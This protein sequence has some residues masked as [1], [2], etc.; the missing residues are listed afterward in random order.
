MNDIQDADEVDL[1]ISPFLTFSL[2]R[3]EDKVSASAS[4]KLKG[5]SYFLNTSVFRTKDGSLVASQLDSRIETFTGKSVRSQVN[6][7]LEDALDVVRQTALDWVSNNP[8]WWSETQR[9]Q[10]QTCPRMRA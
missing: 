3:G 2:R 7:A 4:I 8:A 6:P 5:Q 1:T 10:F 9:E